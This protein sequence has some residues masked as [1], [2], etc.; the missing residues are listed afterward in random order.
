[1]D[2]PFIGNDT[3]YQVHVMWLDSITTDSDME[4]ANR[5]YSENKRST[6]VHSKGWDLICAATVDAPLTMIQEAT[7]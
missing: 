4:P 2:I 5:R 3:L 7:T 6:K 1:M